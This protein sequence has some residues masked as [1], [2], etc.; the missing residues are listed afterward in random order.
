S[1]PYGS[2][3][4]YAG[5][6]RV[7]LVLLTYRTACDNGDRV[8]TPIRHSVQGAFSYVTGSHNIRTGMQWSF[9]PDTQSRT[10]NADLVQ[11]YRSGVPD[12][13]STWPTPIT[14]AEYVVADRGIYAQDAW[15]ISRP[16]LNL[17]VRI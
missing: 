10:G 13:V 3:E 17:G 5:A 15:T 8:E 4:W 14:D 12:S 1:K 16:T 6:P 2:P 7:D 9:G 11:Q